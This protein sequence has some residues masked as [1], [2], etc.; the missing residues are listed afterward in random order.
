[1]PDFESSK[2]NNLGSHNIMAMEILAV[3]KEELLSLL[4]RL[5][6]VDSDPVVSVYHQYFHFAVWPGTVIGKSDLSAHPGCIYAE[7]F[8]QIE[9]VGTL[10]LIVDLSSSFTLLLRDHLPEILRNE[11]ILVGS[12]PEEA[13]PAGDVTRSHIELL[14]QLPLHHHIPAAVGVGVKLYV[15]VQAGGAQVRV[16]LSAGLEAGAR[17]GGALTLALAAREPHPA[18]LGAVAELLAE[19][20]SLTTRADVISAGQIWVVTWRVGHVALP[21]SVLAVTLKMDNNM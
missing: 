7:F 5:V 20:A 3:V 16:T 12:L 8:V 18:V 9:H 2:R 4:Y 11:L 13:A 6:G 19:V 15:A 10:G 14:A 21:L 1:M 17:V